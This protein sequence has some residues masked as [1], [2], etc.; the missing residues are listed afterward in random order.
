MGERLHYWL[1]ISMLLRFT[2]VV[3]ESLVSGDGKRPQP[4]DR[5]A[6]NAGQMASKTRMDVLIARLRL[7][8]GVEPA[9]RPAQGRLVEGRRSSGRL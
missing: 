8:S 6:L 5:A 1:K 4:D 3:R 7:D 9:L 2:R